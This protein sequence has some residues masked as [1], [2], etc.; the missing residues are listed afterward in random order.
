MNNISGV[1]ALTFD[2][3]GTVLDLGGSLTPYIVD[4]LKAKGS[5]TAPERFWELWR[6]RQRIEQYQ[7][8][9]M[10]LGHSGYLETARRGLVWTLKYNDVPFTPAEVL[11]LM[12]AWQNLSPFPE[13]VSELHRLKK[14][15]SLV[16]L[17]NGE[18]H[19]LDHLAKNRIQYDFDDIISVETVGAFKPH[20]GVYRRAA[21]ILGLE[22]GA[23]MMVSSN[24][25]D[26]V[27]ARACGFRGAFVDRYGHPYEDTAFQPDV[28]VSNF[29]GLANALL[30]K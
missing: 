17:S 10:M 26:V 2:L 7:D 21:A 18:P 16:A 6:Y 1:K 27:G 13:V 19:F 22:V 4:F 15:F 23:C 28:I 30:K 24:S 25:F 3:F 11:E 29:T 12:E 5:D 8:T 14:R 20:P 9:I